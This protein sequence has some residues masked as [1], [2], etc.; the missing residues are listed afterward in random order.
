MDKK[1]CSSSATARIV[2]VQ[3]K[4]V[5]NIPLSCMGVQFFVSLQ[6]KIG[7]VLEMLQLWTMISHL[8]VYSSY[9]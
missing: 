3:E 2:C 8:T 5:E 6:I 7:M 4:K 9:H 1:S